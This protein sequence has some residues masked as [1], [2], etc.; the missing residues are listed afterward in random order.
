MQQI[1]FN[2]DFNISLSKAYTNYKI[3]V[4]WPTLSPIKKYIIKLCILRAAKKSIE[5]WRCTEYN[6]SYLYFHI[7]YHNNHT[8]HIYL[9][10][11]K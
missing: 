5:S 2:P 10:I 3:R 4:A 9:F 1:D 8:N 6:T 7:K 11:T